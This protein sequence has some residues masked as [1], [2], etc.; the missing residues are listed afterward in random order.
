MDLPQMGQNS[1]MRIRHLN[2]LAKKVASLGAAS[3]IQVSLSCPQALRYDCLLK[4]FNLHYRF[5]D[6]R[7][8][9]YITGFY[10]RSGFW[11]DGIAI[12]TSL[13]RK[14]PVFGNA[15]GGSGSV[16]ATPLYL[17]QTAHGQTSPNTS[18]RICHCWSFRI[19]RRMG[20]WI[21]HHSHSVIVMHE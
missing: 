21:W 14:S 15:N 18:K 2:F 11:V 7:R 16:K 20:R 10:V 4:A 12:M 1:Y 5:S 8:G 3:I 9:E 13:G 17:P 6:T 19:V